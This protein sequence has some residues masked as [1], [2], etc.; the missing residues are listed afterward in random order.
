MFLF[1]FIPEESL[2]KHPP[3]ANLIRVATKP[4]DVPNM[5]F[6]IPKGMLVLIPVFAIHHDPLYYKQP[7]E[8]IPE[9][10]SPD[11]VKTRP[12]C[13]FLPFGE[14]LKL[15]YCFFVDCINIRYILLTFSLYISRPTKLY[16]T[17]IWNASSSNRFDLS[18]EE[19]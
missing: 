5:K 8:F 7:E 14:G 13:S 12:S 10:F 6:T 3:A 18:F 11:E 2:R 19:F 17:T 9:R 15:L 1:S 4:Y 16:R